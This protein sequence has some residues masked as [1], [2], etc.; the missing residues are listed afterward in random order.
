MTRVLA[1]LAVAF[2]LGACQQAPPVAQPIQFNHQ[3]HLSSGLNCPTCHTTVEQAVPAGVPTLETC[4]MCHQG[5]LTES[6]EEEKV[7][8][9]AQRNESI[10]WRRIYQLPDHVYFSHRRH[11]VTGGVACAVCHGAVESLVVPA[12]YPMVK[13]SMDWCLTCHEARGATADCV[14]CH[15]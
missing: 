3:V 9:F 1:L 13:H 4:M 10:P 6:P 11:V 15:R 5:A 7:R 14:H 12:A 2:V 8:Q